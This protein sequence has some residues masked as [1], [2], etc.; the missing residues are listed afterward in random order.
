M[1][2]VQVRPAR[3]EDVEEIARIQRDTWQIAY[4]TLLP[5]AVLDQVTPEVTRAQW[6]TAIT[7]PPS[8]R[9]HV[10]VALEGTWTVGFAACAPSPDEDAGDRTGSIATLLVEPRWGRR[11]HGSRLL[12]AATD[13]LRADELTT[14]TSWLLEG[15]RASESFYASAGWEPSGLA[16]IL[17]ADGQELR[18]I[19]YHAD[20]TPPP[21]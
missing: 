14:V 17:D 1:A 5:Q 9:H 18:E 15:D 21:A 19:Q 8:P 12:A 16:R 13:H 20:L 10:L 2:D 3:A 11:G 6:A 7:A 4:G